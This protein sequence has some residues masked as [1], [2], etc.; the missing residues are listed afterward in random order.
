MTR[1]WFVVR[2]VGYFLATYAQAGE[3]LH[4]VSAMSAEEA[5]RVGVLVILLLARLHL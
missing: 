1:S 5:K 4:A 2:D 3:P